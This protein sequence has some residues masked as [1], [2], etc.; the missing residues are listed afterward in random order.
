ML[1]YPISQLNGDQLRREIWQATGLRLTV[2]DLIWR[3]GTLQINAPESSEAAI[4]AV[5]AAH[6]PQTRATVN[7]LAKARVDALAGISAKDLT[8]SQVRDLL[9]GIACQVGALDAVGR[10]RPYDEWE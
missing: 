2:Y 9:L 8:A 6:V 3:D 4:A 10:V 5:V 7:A 1:S